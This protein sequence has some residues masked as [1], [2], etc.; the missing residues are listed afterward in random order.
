MVACNR[1]VMPAGIGLPLSR[2]S[3]GMTA[4]FGAEFLMAA[5]F[6]SGFLGLL[7]SVRT[8]ATNRRCEISGNVLMLPFVFWVRGYALLQFCLADCHLRPP[9]FPEQPRHPPV[10]C[11]DN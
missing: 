8:A 11:S 10:E 1:R 5:S 2:I 7:P 9:G 6:R 3:R 4:A